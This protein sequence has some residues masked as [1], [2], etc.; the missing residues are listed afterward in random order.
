MGEG[1]KENP[2]ITARGR[3]VCYSILAKLKD[4]TSRRVLKEYTWRAPS[5]TVLSERRLPANWLEGMEQRGGSTM[6]SSLLERGGQR[7]ESIGREGKNADDPEAKGAKRGTASRPGEAR[8]AA[9]VAVI[10]MNLY[11]YRVS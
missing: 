4:M 3:H 9:N 5:T 7:R 1:G 10:P 6:M 11:A 8:S 2:R